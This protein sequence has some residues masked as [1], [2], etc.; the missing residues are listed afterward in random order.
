MAHLLVI[1]IGDPGL[2]QG[3]AGTPLALS[4][5]IYER[6][7]QAGGECLLQDQLQGSL[8]A[9]LLFKQLHLSKDAALGRLIVKVMEN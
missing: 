6:R 7:E 5:R 9:G 8:F 3:C 2:G 1:E 4:S